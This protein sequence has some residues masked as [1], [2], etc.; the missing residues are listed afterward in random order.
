MVQAGNGRCKGMGGVG[1]GKLGRLERE[2]VG[3]SEPS[4]GFQELSR[5]SEE[6]EEEARVVVTF[7]G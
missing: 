7:Q 3:S 1:D 5:E 6:R 2:R 4:N